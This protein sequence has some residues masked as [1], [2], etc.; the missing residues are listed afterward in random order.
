ME[1]VADLHV[2]SKRIVAT[3]QT[4]VTDNCKKYNAILYRCMIM[5]QILT[6]TTCS[7]QPL[8]F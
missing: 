5:N 4:F 8:L 7:D 2:Y 3:W 6:R 1:G